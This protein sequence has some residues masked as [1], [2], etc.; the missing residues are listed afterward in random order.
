MKKNIVIIDDYKDPFLN[1]MLVDEGFNIQYYESAL[2]ALENL[3][4]QKVD[5]ILL[6]LSMPEMNGFE[7][8]NALESKNYNIPI[9][10]VSGKSSVDAKIAA[11]NMGAVDYVTKPFNYEELLAR[12]KV[13]TKR[14]Q[15]PLALKIADMCFDDF[16]FN[17]EDLILNKGNTSIKLSHYEGELLML[18]ILKKGEIVSRE[19]ISKA[20]WGD[21]I[22]V[23]SKAINVLVSRLRK[24][25]NDDPKNPKYILP[26]QGFGYRFS[27]KYLI[28][29]Q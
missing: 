7:M 9:I 5:L 24:K 4:I 18:L 1:E 13:N 26:V 21:E 12:I 8:L 19:D 25:I 20:V 2:T 28:E 16:R 23:S 29:N 17:S 3:K 27:K 22:F 15:I 6:D 10:I 14:K 11:L